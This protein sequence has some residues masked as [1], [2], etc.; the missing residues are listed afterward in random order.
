MLARTVFPKHYNLMIRRSG[1]W[2]K[3]HTFDVIFP[4]G[5]R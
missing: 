3:Y 4:L 5:N 1:R 2:K